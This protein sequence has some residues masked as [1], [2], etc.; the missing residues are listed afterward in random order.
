MY[1]EKRNVRGKIKYYLAHSFREDGKV[2]KIR[3]LLGT[4]LTKEV[5]EE[6]KNK[7]EKLIL[8]EIEKYKVLK[9]PI[10]TELST[11]EIKFV[12]HLEKEA[13]LKIIHLS[14]DKWA[15]FSE[16]FT[17]NTNAIEGSRL[18]NIEVK[19]ILERGNWPKDKSK[20]DVA[21]TYGVSEAISYIRQTKEHISLNLIKEIHKIV[22]KNSKNF[23]G[24]FRKFGEEVVVMGQEGIVHEGA[25][26]SRV[27]SLLNEL[28]KWYENHKDKYPALILAAV[29]HNQF[30]NI[31]PF[32]DG[33][34]RVGRILLNNILLKKGLPPVN[35]KLNHRFEYYKTLQEYEKNNNL[36]PTIEFILKEYKETKKKIK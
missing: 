30:E 18:T 15:I 20:E 16:L 26:Q 7:A 9:D 11:E 10:E 25:P 34:G 27:I 4:D 21:E 22:F 32:A 3:K 13:N 12:M 36:R 33:N 35:I 17:Y 23:A 14:E 19:E 6:R 5:L 29:V 2:H 1:L 31:H 24:E 8:E 28:I